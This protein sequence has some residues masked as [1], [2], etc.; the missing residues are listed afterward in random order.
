MYSSNSTVFI[1]AIIDVANIQI[2]IAIYVVI[3]ETL[4]SVIHGTAHSTN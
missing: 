3:G 4:F 2:L 1:I